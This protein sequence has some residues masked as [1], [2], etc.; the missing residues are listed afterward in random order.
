M[1]SRNPGDKEDPKSSAARRREVTK[2]MRKE[3]NLIST[4]NVTEDIMNG[5]L[6]GDGLQG[7]SAQEKNRRAQKRFRE[8]QKAS[9]NSMQDQMK[10]MK[11]EVQR[12]EKENKELAGRNTLLDKMLRLS[13]DSILCLQQKEKLL[14]LGISYG[15]NVAL[16]DAVHAVEKVEG[17]L[18][19][20]LSEADIALAMDGQQLVSY[21]KALV[22]DLS[23]LLV[24]Y[25]SRGED[26]D[27]QKDNIVQSMKDTLDR[28]GNICMQAAVHNPANL[29]FLMGASLDGGLSGA[30]IRDTEHWSK[31]AQDIV[32]TSNQKHQIDALNQI[33]L[34]RMGKIQE[35]CMEKLATLRQVGPK[36]G[37]RCLRAIVSDTLTISESAQEIHMKMQEEHLCK[38]EFWATVFKT[39]LNDVQKARC[40]VQSYPFFPD[41]QL[42]AAHI[43]REIDSE[44]DT[45]VM[46]Y[47]FNP[48]SN[49]SS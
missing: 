22:K 28:A 2:A 10:S 45:V 43:A 4:L 9:I 46:N 38:V 34:E 17:E 29:E 1:L 33:F 15:E 44:Q 42:M 32:L 37:N 8:R 31:I 19:D 12:L 24:E 18:I 23:V 35:A 27:N 11:E 7:T 13:N 5:N 21:W 36:D 25:D 49:A 6:S 3:S 16:L 40:I 41:V 48:D 26:E 39:V 20:G 47:G 30:S 14:D